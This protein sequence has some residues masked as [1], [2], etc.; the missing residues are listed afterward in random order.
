[1]KYDYIVV[2][3]RLLGIERAKAKAEDKIVQEI[4][5]GIEGQHPGAEVLSVSVID[6]GDGVYAYAALRIPEVRKAGSK[7]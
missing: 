2:R 7:V 5:A 1:M 3:E 6:A 4:L